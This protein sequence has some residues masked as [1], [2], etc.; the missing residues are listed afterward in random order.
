MAIKD[1]KKEN[2]HVVAF[3]SS[4]QQLPI[5][6]RHASGYNCLLRLLSPYGEH[7]VENPPIEDEAMDEDIRY[8]TRQYNIIHE[9]A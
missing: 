3:P 7:Y 9:K 2:I 1:T 8:T 4:P 5:L 6:H